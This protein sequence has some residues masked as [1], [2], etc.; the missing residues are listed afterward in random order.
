MWL[1][2]VRLETGFEEI[3]NR[4]I[5]TKTEL[6]CIRLDNGTIAEITNQLPEDTENVLD[7]KNYLLLPSLRDNHMHLDKGHYGGPWRA[8]IPASSVSERIK[9]EE[10]FLEDFLV[11]T[12]KKAQALIDLICNYGVT[13]LRIQVNVDP[14]IELK[15]LDIIQEVLE[16]NR[17]R[18]DYD[19]VAFP[20]HGT[21]YTEK[22]GLLSKAAKDSRVQVMGGVDPATLDF[23]IEKSLRTTFDLAKENKLRVDIHLHDRGELGMYEINRMIDYTVEYEMQGK[24]DISHALSMGDVSKE[25]LI[26]VLKRLAKE[27][28]EINTTVPIDV[29]ALPIPLLQEYG[30]NVHIVND[31]INDHWSPFGTGDMIERASRAAEVFSLVDEKS[32]SQTLGLVTNGVTPL[33][34]QGMQVWPQVGD[35]ANFL[36]TTAESSAHLVARVVPERVVM[37]KGEVVAGTFK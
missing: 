34:K 19:I 11:D 3:E 36:F 26:P 25:A 37:F 31:N 6:K 2:N 14:V 30:V 24:V 33:D 27:K 1:K 16:K 22:K 9:E 29:P 32:L 23:D 18:L 17:H 35:A 20:Q 13:F 21:I 7:A 15:N 4:G 12:P 8:V 5:V 28:I 10:G